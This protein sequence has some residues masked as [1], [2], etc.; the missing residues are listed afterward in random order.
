MNE[1][2]LKEETEKLETNFEDVIYLIQEFID[3]PTIANRNQLKRDVAVARKQL[4]KVFKYINERWLK[5]E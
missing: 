5:G 3:K 4:N 1:L 2:W